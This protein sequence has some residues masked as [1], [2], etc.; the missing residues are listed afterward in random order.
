M[1][2]LLGDLI[3]QYNIICIMNF[4]SVL[5]G[6]STPESDVDY[7]GI[8]LPTK[9]QILLQEIPK[10][11]KADT[12]DKHSGDKNTKDDV[13]IELYSLSYFLELCLKGETV[14]MDML[15]CNNDNIIYKDGKLWDFI[16]CNRKTFYTNNLKGFVGYCR[17]QAAKYGVKGSRISDARRVLEFLQTEQEKHLI[18]NKGYFPSPNLQ[19]YW[20]SLPQGDHI[21]FV[22]G[23]KKDKEEEF[24]QFCGKKMQKTSNISYCIGILKRFIDSYGHR[25]LLAEKNKGID[26]KAVSHAIRYGMQIKELFLTGDI[27]F[28]LK[29]RYFLRKVKN[30]EL[31][32]IKQV[33]P[34]LEG[35]MDDIESLSLT[36]DLPSKPNKKLWRELLLDIHQAIVNN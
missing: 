25:A 36:V 10:H 8:F 29:K 22:K 6:T 31:N 7:K 33:A 23:G 15:H 32:Y 21:H 20:E 17:K 16:R 19:N 34:V 2:K 11:I 4:G 13:D 28:P 18:I 3:K 1:N 5:Y 9:E 27:I 12:K 14:G 26:W 30:G 24:Y 35:L